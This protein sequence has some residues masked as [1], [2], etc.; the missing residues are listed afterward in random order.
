MDRLSAYLEVITIK[1]R[2]Q[3]GAGPL[4]SRMHQIGMRTGMLNGH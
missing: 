2:D 1:H 3:T 4:M